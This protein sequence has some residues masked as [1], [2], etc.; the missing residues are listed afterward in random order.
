VD[1]ITGDIS[2]ELSKFPDEHF[3]KLFSQDGDAWMHPA[4]HIIM[5]EIFRVTANNGQFIFQSYVC[6]DS[7]PDSALIKTEKLLHDFGYID[8][9]VPR[10]EEI[11][12]MFQI[13]G[14]RIESLTPLHKLYSDDNLRILKCFEENRETKLGKF[15][16]IEIENL[17]NWL[18]WEKILFSEGWW[19]GVLVV[20][21]K[22]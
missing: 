19:S 14:F 11:H 12:K 9:D 22:G 16:K 1:L 15:P 5:S 20:A 21:R 10:L 4:K 2:E 17:E 18:K 6:S 8:A 7:M 3:T 13:A